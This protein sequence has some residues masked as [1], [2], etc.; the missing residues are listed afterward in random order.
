MPEFAS[1]IFSLAEWRGA[2]RRVLHCGYVTFY[3][4]GEPLTHIGPLALLSNDGASGFG[5]ALPLESNARLHPAVV[6]VV[7]SRRNFRY[8][9]RNVAVT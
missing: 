9:D 8:T 7:K 2:A 3:V 4:V 1:V 5:G 6:A